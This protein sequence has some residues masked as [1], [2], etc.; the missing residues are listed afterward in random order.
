MTNVELSTISLEVTSSTSPCQDDFGSNKFSSLP[1]S[2]VH[3]DE[4]SPTISSKVPENQ[5]S[6]SSRRTSST[7]TS[8]VC[9]IQAGVQLGVTEGLP[10]TNFESSHHTPCQQIA[11]PSAT[12]K[13]QEKKQRNT[14]QRIWKH[15]KVHV[16][17]EIRGKV[18][19]TGEGKQDLLVLI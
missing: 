11:V 5:D 12:T 9:S 3:G 2:S 1:P 4:A 10:K 18:K 7:F 15:L 13:P 8:T 16:Q 17:W 14:F 6:P 19:G